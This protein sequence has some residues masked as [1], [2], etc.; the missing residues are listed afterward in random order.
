LKALVYKGK[1]TTNKTKRFV[2][3]E[4]QKMP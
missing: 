3:T 4:M 1:I 2:S